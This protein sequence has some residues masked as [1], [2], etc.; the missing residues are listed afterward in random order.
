MYTKSADAV[1]FTSLVQRN[2]EYGVSCLG[3]FVGLPTFPR[4]ADPSR[5][6]P[7]RYQKSQIP[8]RHREVLSAALMPP[9]RVGARVI[10]PAA[11]HLATSSNERAD[12]HRRYLVSR[13]W[14]SLDLSR[15][16]V[17]CLSR[18]VTRTAEYRGFPG[19]SSTTV[20]TDA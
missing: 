8:H 4:L 11:K 10:R 3:L 14:W 17:H 15:N 6:L 19:F 20:N 9:S 13:D 16:N 18:L 1:R 7:L 12:K 2:R 5:H